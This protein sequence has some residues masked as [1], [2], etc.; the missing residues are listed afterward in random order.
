NAT[1]ALAILR[2]RGGRK[3]PPQLMRMR[4]DD[5]LASVFPDQAACAENLTGP[6]RIPDHVL[7]RETISNCLHEAMDIDG[8]KAILSQVEAGE[9]R[10]V[11][12]DTPE[13]SPFCHEILNA[14]PY[15]YLDDAPLEERRARAVQMRRTIRDDVDGAGVLD[16]AVIAEVAA[17]SW[18]V[19]RDADEL[20]DALAT[21]TLV[22]PAANW[23]GWFDE[24][25]AQRRAQ[26]VAAPDGSSL[27]TC[28]ERLER[29]RDAF[30]DDAERRQE[31]VTE[32]V[33]GWLEC[34][35]PVTAE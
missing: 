31:A 28:A 14:N 26:V 12:V 15:A 30:G 10:T 5:L 22:P 23:L 13:P 35:G 27:W 32:I 2:M 11:A 16:A 20:H 6:I 25:V 3:V 29:A 19:V 21:L 33:R 17:E 4:A 18:P 34:S 8:L 24:L 9:I 1:R 7:V